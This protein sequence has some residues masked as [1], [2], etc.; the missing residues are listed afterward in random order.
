MKRINRIF[1]VISI[2]CIASI[3]LLITPSYSRFVYSGTLSGSAVVPS[4]MVNITYKYYYI[5]E[6]NNKVEFKEPVTINYI[7]GAPITLSDTLVSDIDY[8]E[9]KYYINNTLYT[10][11]TYIANNNVI[12]EE[13]YYLNI[14]TI[15]YHLN[16]GVLTDTPVTEYTSVTETFSLPT[17]TKIG[18]NFLGWS[19][20]MQLEEFSTI[21]EASKLENNTVYDTGSQRNRHIYIRV[22]SGVGYAVFT[23]YSGQDRLVVYTDDNNSI[24]QYS[25]NQTNWTRINNWLTSGE[26]YYQYF[27]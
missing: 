8:S 10:D 3:F 1:L 21:Q 15:T 23:N 9:V 24:I 6:L 16:D 27:R 5:D 11:S 13:D 25:T 12:V 19:R 20:V 4:K 14:Y 22:T 26:L 2:F 7:R 17:P 18:N